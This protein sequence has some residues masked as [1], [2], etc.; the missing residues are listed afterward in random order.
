MHWYYYGAVARYLFYNCLLATVSKEVV[1][2]ES[3]TDVIV[4]V[5]SGSS[6]LM[7]IFYLRTVFHGMHSHYEQVASSY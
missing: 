3:E 1:V 2:T 7:Y 4:L 6:K 5:L